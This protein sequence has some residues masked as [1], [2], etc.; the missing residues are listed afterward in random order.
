[1]KNL[2]INF[3]NIYNKFKL[4]K[5]SILKNYK[6]DLKLIQILNIYMMTLN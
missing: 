6:I 5:N 2:K 1:M 4:G 3:I